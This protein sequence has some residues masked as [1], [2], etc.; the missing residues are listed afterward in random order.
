MYGRILVP[1]DGSK[2]STQGLDEAIRLATHLNAEIRLIHVVD[3]LPYLLIGASREIT[4]ESVQSLRARGQAMLD[5]GISRARRAEVE[6]DGV[7]VEAVGGVAGQH[8]L[9]YARECE[10]DLIVCGTHGRRG[11]RRIVM[12]SDAEY[13]VRHTPVPVL[14]V[15]ADARTGSSQRR[16]AAIATAHGSPSRLSGVV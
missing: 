12:G 2:A 14:L 7:L 10:A 8:V 4:E 11:L 15:R 16:A 1:V 5:E 6:C 3:E 13:I 9:D